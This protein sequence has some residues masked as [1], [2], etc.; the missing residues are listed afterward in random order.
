MEVL[1]VGP[2][3]GHHRAVNV[4]HI[5]KMLEFWATLC[6]QGRSPQGEA[7]STRL[8]VETAQSEVHVFTK[9]GSSTFVPISVDAGPFYCGTH[10]YFSTHFHSS[11]PWNSVKTS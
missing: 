9:F 3:Y 5:L 8:N 7:M 10:I 11:A 2:Q 1:R 4:V 6:K